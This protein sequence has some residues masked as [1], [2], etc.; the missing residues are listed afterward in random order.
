MT[1]IEQNILYKLKFKIIEKFGQ[2]FLA[3]RKLGL[4]EDHLSAIIHGRR[5]LTE[6]LIQSFE[7]VLDCDR[8]SFLP[9]EVE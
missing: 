1:A 5:P 7:Q 6:S 8:D 4:R 2:Q 3:A 9:G